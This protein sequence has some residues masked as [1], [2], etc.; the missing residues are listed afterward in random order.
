LQSLNNTE[1]GCK[2]GVG[3]LIKADIIGAFKRLIE[4]KC[5]LFFQAAKNYSFEIFKTM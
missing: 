4:L 1:Y 5:R 3:N 2:N